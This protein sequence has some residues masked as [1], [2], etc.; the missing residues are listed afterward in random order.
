MNPPKREPYTP[1]LTYY[2]APST[3]WSRWGW[4]TAAGLGVIVLLALLRI[5]C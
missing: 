4:P 2:P 1:K 3:W 5:A